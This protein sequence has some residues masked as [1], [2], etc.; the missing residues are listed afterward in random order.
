MYGHGGS[1]DAIAKDLNS[2][3]HSSTFKHPSDG[4]FAKIKEL[5]SSNAYSNYNHQEQNHNQNQN[6]IM[7]NQNQHRPN[8]GGQTKT[9]LTSYRS[10][11]SSF[12]ANLLDENDFFSPLDTTNNEPDDAFFSRQPQQQQLTFQ[13]SSKSMK[14]ET[15]KEAIRV[16]SDMYGGSTQQVSH[17][18]TTNNNGNYNHHTGNLDSSSTFRSMS[19]NNNLIR[20]SSSPAGFLSALNSENGLRK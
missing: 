17:M 14:L 2:L 10:A 12:F 11:P 1:S 9:S 15:E 5:I 7:Q 20:Q 13:P 6:Q 18:Q 16:S 4:G 8:I 3:L 19:S